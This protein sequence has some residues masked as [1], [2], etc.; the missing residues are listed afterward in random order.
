MRWTR[1]AKRADAEIMKELFAVEMRLE[2]ENLS[3]DGELPRAE[4]A[5]KYKQLM[6]QRS[7][8]IQ[9]LGREPSFDELLAVT[10]KDK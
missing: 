10:R 7:V 6:K 4:V 3:N 1:V 9:E 8:L 5:R 2:P